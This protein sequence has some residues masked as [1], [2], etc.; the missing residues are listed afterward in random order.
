MSDQN[1]IDITLISESIKLMTETILIPSIKS[2]TDN[3]KTFKNVQAESLI[4]SLNKYFTRLYKKTSVVNIIAMK[5]KE[6]LLDDIY[7]PLNLVH[8]SKF[9]KI[10]VEEYNES[11]FF[12]NKIILITDT[13]GMGKSTISRKLITSIIIKSAGIPILIELRR[14]SKDHGIID[15]ILSQFNQINKEF[16]K[17]LLLQMISNGNFFFFFDGFDEIPLSEKKIATTY[18][19]HF[20]QQAN[21]N[22]NHFVIT[23][24][25]EDSLI[26]FG[27]AAEYSIEDLDYQNALELIKKY[28]NNGEV[29]KNL[30]SK[31]SDKNI[32]D[33]ISDFLKTPLLVSLLFSAFEHKENIPFKKYLF[34]RQVFDALYETHDLSKGDAYLRDK[35]TNLS[36]DDF[37]RLLRCFG[38]ICLKLGNKIEFNKDQLINALNESLILSKNIKA[39]PSDI[40]YDILIAVPIFRKDGIYFKWSHK[41][42]QEYFASQ[43]IY[44]D[45]KE[46][47]EKVLNYIAFNDGNSAYIN[48]LDLFKSVDENS[49]EEIVVLKY[50]NDLLAFVEN[51]K[52]IFPGKNI[53]NR[54]Y[55][56]FNK[57]ILAFTLTKYDSGNDISNTD[58][59]MG[60]CI[61]RIFTE[62][63]SPKHISIL[64]P[65]KEYFGN[66]GNLIIPDINNR[67]FHLIYF[68][69]DYEIFNYHKNPNNLS[70][71]HI[72][73]YIK[74][75]IIIDFAEDNKSILN[76]DDNFDEV[77]KLFYYYMKEKVVF[78]EKK[79]REKI[80][81]I[82][83]KKSN[84]FLL[85]ILSF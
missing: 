18:L 67:Y 14:I 49:F 37:H 1:N 27:E 63:D 25:P 72:K 5:R 46:N 79:L 68:I 15:E 52:T 22:N 45:T 75:S 6:V 82:S 41:S 21:N 73:H 56:H 76:N 36:I 38:F 33:S 81:F 58:N 55:Y 24:R 70:G 28:D 57:K 12:D 17:E 47:L 30:I 19:T 50:L 80:D 39:N 84:K 32:L 29:S 10:Q 59:E 26:S 44:H 40:I 62:Y 69:K 53:E 74:K 7:I 77:S 60:K 2:I 35:K 20:I 8:K 71:I 4:T 42:L 83:N 65:I 61:N 3:Q 43:Y 54:I 31:I 11:I 9:N 16:N 13:A 23:S 78:N 66:I 64:H 48:T 85:D 51:F 34:Y